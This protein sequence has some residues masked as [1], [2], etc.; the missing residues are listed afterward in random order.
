VNSP[1]GVENSVL[2]VERFAAVTIGI[3]LK[4]S[5]SPVY[6]QMKASGRSSSRPWADAFGNS[7]NVRL[8]LI[9]LFVP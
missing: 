8:I 6:L 2:A 7:K 9:A 5:E 1:F 4:L 3:Q